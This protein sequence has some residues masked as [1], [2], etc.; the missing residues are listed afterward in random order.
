V[1]L[2]LA[3]HGAPVSFMRRPVTCLHDRSTRPLPID[4]APTPSDLFGKATAP[5]IR[6]ALIEFMQFYMLNLW[7]DCPE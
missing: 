4:A 1:A 6:Q 7:P 5:L 2:R 3:R